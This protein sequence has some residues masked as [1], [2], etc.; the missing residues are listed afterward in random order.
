MLFIV[1]AMLGNIAKKLRLLGFDAEYF[2]DI[3][4]SQLVEKAKIENRILISRD[5]KFSCSFNKEW[6]VFYLHLKR[7]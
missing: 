5:K 1:D 3:D 2:S 4:D 6:G 7:R